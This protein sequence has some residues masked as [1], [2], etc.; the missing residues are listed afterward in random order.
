MPDQS[1]I[2]DFVNGSMVQRLQKAFKEHNDIAHWNWT[3]M[4]PGYLAFMLEIH[5]AQTKMYKGN[6]ES[7]ADV[8][9]FTR[10]GSLDLYLDQFLEHSAREMGKIV[11]GVETIQDHFATQTNMPDDLAE[12]DL[13]ITLQRFYEGGLQKQD[14]DMNNKVCN[15]R[16]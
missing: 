4:R 1:T 6:A 13:D 15:I 5:Y 8:S 11:G 12:Y 14:V 2:Q 16:K 9:T 3:K 10:T 7:T